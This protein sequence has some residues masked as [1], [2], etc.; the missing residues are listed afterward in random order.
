MTAR[1]IAL[2]AAG[3]DGEINAAKSR[4]GEKSQRRD[5]RPLPGLAGEA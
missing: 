5:P 4:I 3:R 1:A 2:G